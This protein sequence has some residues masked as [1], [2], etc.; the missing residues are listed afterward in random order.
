MANIILGYLIIGLILSGLYVWKTG[1]TD[2]MRALSQSKYTGLL[3]FTV[4]LI[5]IF[6]SLI[7][8]FALVATYRQ[9]KSDE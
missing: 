9:L 5:T 8:I 2:K 4:A 1:D 7:G 6:W 3:L